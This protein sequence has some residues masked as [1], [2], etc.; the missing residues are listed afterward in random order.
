V[1]QART[2]VKRSEELGNQ[3]KLIIK[4]GRGH[5]WPEM[6]EDMETA[7]DWFDEHLRG[8]SAKTN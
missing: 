8:K 4:S 2:F 3:T 6:R 7:A 1:D 5:G